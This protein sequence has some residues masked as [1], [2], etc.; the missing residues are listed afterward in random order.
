MLTSKQRAGL[1]AIAARF[2]PI[3]QVGKGGIN[4]NM[5]KQINEALETRELIKLRVLE[6]SEYN[7]KEAA[8]E[9]SENISADVVQVIGT[10]FV[11][12][13]ESESCKRID[14][15]AVERG[16]FDSSILDKP[17]KAPKTSDKPKTPA[18][19]KKTEVKPGYK[20]TA[21]LEQKN[22]FPMKRSFSK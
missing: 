5:L 12:Y 7:A 10:K 4:D 13:K 2:E 20:A 15:S 17:A 21:K 11:L 22:A 9:I 18:K 3:F 16:T 14:L 19:R 1:R 6:N 8:A